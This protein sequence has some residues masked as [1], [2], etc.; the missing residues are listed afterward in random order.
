MNEQLLSQIKLTNPWLEDP[1]REILDLSE[2]MP[3]LQTEHLLSPE[4][5]K[6]WLILLGPRRAGKTTLGKYLSLRFK[7]SER[8]DGLLYLN[9]DYYLI[10]QFL[11]SPLAIKELQKHFHLKKPVIFIDEVQRLENPGLLLKMIVDLELPMKMIATGSSQLE[12]RSKVQEFLTG[13]QLSTIILPLSSQELGAKFDWEKLA[14]YGSYPQVVTSSEKNMQLGQLYDDYIK[15]DIV[16]ILKIGKPDILQKLLVLIAHSSGQLVNFNQLSTDCGVTIKTIQHY[17]SILEMTFVIQRIQPFVGNKRTEITSNPIYYF[18]DNGF[19][20][21]AL[22]N[23]TPLQSRMDNGL[24]IQNLIFQELLK[25]KVQCFLNFSIHY[26]RTKS[27]AEVDFVLYKNPEN[28]IPIEVKFQNLPYPAIT[29]A[30]RSFLAAYQ[31]LFGVVI[32]KNIMAEAEFEGC[33][34]HFIPLS[35]L[36]TLFDLIL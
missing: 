12:I 17:L 35:Q 34:V 29:R 21:Y 7:Q 33:K 13:R 20:N 30:Y 15:K 23:F 3:R 6:Q 14:L 1:S 19:R 26:W 8:F 4:W 25:F 36:R 22:A 18:I 27:G 9:C 5:D 24:L 28:F 16:D 32:N 10:R 11:D 31:P 2:Y